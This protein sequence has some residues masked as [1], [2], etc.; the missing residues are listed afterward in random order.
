MSIEIPR[1]YD[2]VQY[3]TA[4]VQPVVDPDTN[5][6]TMQIAP[7]GQETRLDR[8]LWEQFAP[9]CFAV[10][11]APHRVKLW[12]EHG[13]PLIGHGITVEDRDGG[14]WMKARF[15]NTLAAQEA[16]GLATPD[17]D[18]ATLDQVSVT[19]RPDPDWM[20]VRRAA[21]GIHVTHTKATLLG[22]ALVAH[23]QYADG[24]YVASVRSQEDIDRQREQDRARLVASYR[25]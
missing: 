5:T 7:Y 11:S 1:R 2:G 18:G 6:I 22:A 8:D 14:V 23:G 19:F 15:A 4:E 20:K 3:R 24:G 25:H 12:H 17:E 13:G 9:G 21:D 16:R 10:T